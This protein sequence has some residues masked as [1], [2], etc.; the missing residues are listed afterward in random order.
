MNGKVVASNRRARFE[1]DLLESTEA[2][3]VLTGQEVKSC[4]MG[5]VDLKGAYVTFR[6]GK[7][8]LKS[9][10]IQPYK[11]ASNLSDYDPG[12]DRELLLAKKD[13]DR[14]QGASEQQGVTVIPIEVRA[15][16]FIK[17]LIAAAKGRKTID[18]RRKI[19]EKD[20][21]KRLRRGEEV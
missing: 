17:V 21:Q 11:Y 10:T 13:I 14:L 1:Y 15:G 20:I 18:K 9:V 3:V 12:R 5:H 16:R 19:K 6:S 7:P 8:I 4:R 2:G